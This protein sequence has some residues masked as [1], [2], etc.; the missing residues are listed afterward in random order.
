MLQVDFPDPDQLNSATHWVSLTPISPTNSKFLLRPL[1]KAVAP[2]PVARRFGTSFTFDVLI[3]ADLL[4]SHKCCHGG[5]G[6]LLQPVEKLSV[7][8]HDR[9]ARTPAARRLD[10]QN[11]TFQDFDPIRC[12]LKQAKRDWRPGVPLG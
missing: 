4:F 5:I 11:K 3:Q 7:C 6:V 12:V 10:L 9:G 2:F 8:L 1:F